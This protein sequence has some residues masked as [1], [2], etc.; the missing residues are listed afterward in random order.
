M[1]ASAFRLFDHLSVFKHLGG[2]GI[3]IGFGNRNG[4]FRFARLRLCGEKFF[5][6]CIDSAHFQNPRSGTMG[7][8][9]R[10]PFFKDADVAGKLKYYSVIFFCA[11][12]AVSI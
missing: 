8:F 4:D 11:A 12:G 3:I 7:N 9:Q 6:E 10:K 2:N 5:A 1:T